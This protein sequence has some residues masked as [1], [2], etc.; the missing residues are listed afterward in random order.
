MKCGYLSAAM[1]PIEMLVFPTPDCVPAMTTTGHSLIVPHLTTLDNHLLTM[2]L[3]ARQCRSFGLTRLCCE[4]TC[5]LPNLVLRPR[6]LSG[7]PRALYPLRPLK[8]R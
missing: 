4:L 3:Q 7:Q 8:R 2:P 1:M 6:K 5:A